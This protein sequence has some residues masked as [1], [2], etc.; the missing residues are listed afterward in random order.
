MVTDSLNELKSQ[1]LLN[2]IREMNILRRID[3]NL[4][5]TLHALLIEKHVSRAAL[6]LHKSQP[7]VSHALANLREIFDDPLLVRRAGKLE[8]TARASELLQPL[9][10][11]LDQLGAL[12]EQPA[13]EPAQAKRAFRLAMSD[14]GAGV[15]L[16]GLARL[17]RGQAPGIDLEIVQ[18]SR[19]SMLASVHEGTADLA[20]GVFPQ[21]LPDE[22]RT[23]ALFTERF[24]CAADKDTL[25]KSGR[26]S[27]KQWLARPH[28]LVAMQSSENN[29]IENALSREGVSRR[30]ALSLPHW[31]VAGRL[32]ANTDLVLTAARRTF[33]LFL[34]DPRLQVFTPP[35]PIAPFDFTMVWHSR[36]ESD[37]A[38][39]WLRQT[40]VTMLG[41]QG[42]GPCSS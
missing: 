33:D 40:I 31:G 34:E 21:D 41:D 8:R 12:I 23:H 26:L 25:P 15:I 2:T 30:V 9:T 37:P 13:F 14:Y 1:F 29:E 27:R 7:A 38:H 16:P 39:N 42:S 22:L 11:A 17:L 5:V 24:A 6:R 4:L 18:G 36:R 20:F 28:V 35:F 3:L 32:M 10:E 19:T